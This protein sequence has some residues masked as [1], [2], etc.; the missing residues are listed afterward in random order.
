MKEAVPVEISVADA[1]GGA[2]GGHARMG[3]GDTRK[4]G[5]RRVYYIQRQEVATANTPVRDNRR[6]VYNREGG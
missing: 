3:P 5:V 1:G 6:Q 4:R 2:G